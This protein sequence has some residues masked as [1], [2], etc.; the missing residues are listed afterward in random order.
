MAA[1]AAVEGVTLHGR[2]R[3]PNMPLRYKHNSVNYKAEEASKI[4]LEY[5]KRNVNNRFSLW[6][7]SENK[8]LKGLSS[9]N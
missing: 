6:R 9:E 3:R 8:I 7:I 5:N 1:R 4:S 2:W